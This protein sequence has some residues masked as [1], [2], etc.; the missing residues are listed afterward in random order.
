MG[1]ANTKYDSNTVKLDNPSA[2]LDPDRERGKVKFYSKDNFQ[3]NIY[4]VETG[5]Y[6]SNDFIPRISPDN[7][8][9]MKIPPQTY[10]KVYGGDIY[11][12][13][14]RGFMYIENVT[15]QVMRVPILPEF[16][17]GLVRSVSIGIHSDIQNWAGSNSG[18]RYDRPSDTNVNTSQKVD[19]QV[20]IYSP[21]N[22]EQ[23]N[24]QFDD[25]VNGDEWTYS[26]VALMIS[27]LLF[28]LILLQFN[29]K[30]L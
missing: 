6:T 19:D 7:V 15:D 16:I 10:V 23:F 14:G 9:S 26:D 18:S 5:N 30:K 27:L 3:G 24:V 1:G 11:D 2:A 28:V 21:N 20:S 29:W 17:Q 4:E 8:F 22:Y 12:Y 25:K 13:G